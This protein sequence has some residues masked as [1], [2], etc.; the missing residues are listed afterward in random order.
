MNFFSSFLCFHVQHAIQCESSVSFV[1]NCME[2]RF[3][4]FF[5]VHEYFFLL[6]FSRISIVRA[7]VLYDVPSLRTF[8]L[9]GINACEFI[10][11]PLPKREKN[12]EWKSYVGDLDINR[13]GVGQCCCH[14]FS[15]PNHRHILQIVYSVHISGLLVRSSP[16]VALVTKWW[17]NLTFFILFS[18]SLFNYRCKWIR[19][20][21][22]FPLI[23][24]YASFIRSVGCNF[25][26]R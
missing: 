16:T 15:F 25:N 26:L 4:V 2:K 3:G 24:W 22:C 14:F 11:S 20:K 6:L 12:V 13:P 10:F 17:K 19:N 7:L 23:I 1:K 18:R 5:L 9:N 8:G 21:H